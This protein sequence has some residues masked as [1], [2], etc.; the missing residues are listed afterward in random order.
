[1]KIDRI[2]AEVFIEQALCPSCT[3]G[4]LRYVP[5]GD[6]PERFLHRH[7]CPMCSHVE[8]LSDQYPVFKFEPKDGA[9]WTE[10]VG[11]HQRV[12]TQIELPRGDVGP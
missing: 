12:I 2:A 4:Y 11:S 9:K 3:S 6:D 7:S 5:V 10:V 8:Y 1:M